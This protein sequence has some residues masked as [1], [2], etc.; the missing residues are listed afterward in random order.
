MQEKTMINMTENNGEGKQMN[1]EE[2]GFLTAPLGKLIVRNATPAVASMLFMAFYQIVDGMMVGR[3]LGPEAL[4]SV[5]VLYPILALL[6][7]FGVMIGVGGN[8]RIAV[9]LG[10]GQNREAGRVLGLVV[11]LAVGIGLVGTVAVLL[12]MP[13]ILTMLGTSG[14]LGL[15]AA[16]YLKGMLPFF[17]FLI[18]FFVLEQSL[19][20]DGQANLASGVMAFCSV[21]NIALDYL[22]LYVLNLGIMGASL[23]SGMSQTLGVFIFVGYFA[24]KHFHNKGGLR[25][26]KP[27]FQWST[28]WAI[29]VNGSSEMLNSLA[30]G[31]T[32][33]FLNRAL[34]AHIGSLGVAAFTLVQYLLMLGAMVIMGV[35]NGTQPILSYNYGAGQHDRVKGVFWRVMGVSL[36]MGTF[37]FWMMTW[38]MEILTLWFVDGH[39]ETLVLTMEAAQTMRWSML[40]K[41]LAMMVSIYFTALEQARWSLIIALCH[42]LMLPLLG[43]ALFPRW[44]GASGIWNALVF[45]DGVA[46][47][48]AAGCLAVWRKR[49]GAEKM[50][51]LE[52]LK[53]PS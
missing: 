19:R 16:D 11:L 49:T 4:A 25:I 20:N 8:A 18:L 36:V 2:Q 10:G 35:G 6:V 46:V 7:G 40:L 14:S 26:R 21:L 52:E 39:R 27:G 42:S 38:G 45:A 34:L 41:P 31:I 12:L 32:T 22:F 29:A 50:T 23:A 53:S 37:F 47:L 5:N 33:F 48:V 28:V 24:Q 44:W 30:M 15:Y 9:L 43:L 1:S 17:V 13:M 3:R 51:R